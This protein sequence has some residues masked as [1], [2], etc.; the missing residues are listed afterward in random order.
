[1]INED[2]DRDF[3]IEVSSTMNNASQLHQLRLTEG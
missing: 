2:G 3:I 1:M